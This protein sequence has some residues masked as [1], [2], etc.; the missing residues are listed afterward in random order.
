MY[1]LAEAISVKADWGHSSNIVGVDLCQMRRREDLCLFH[2]EP[3]CDDAAHRRAADGDAALRG[4]HAQR[5]AAAR[6]RRLRR[7]GNR[8]VR[9]A[10]AAPSGA[11]ASRRVRIAARRADRAVLLRA[12]PPWP[13]ACRRPGST[14]YQVLAPRPITSMPVTSSRSTRRASSRS[15]SGRGRAPAGPAGRRDRRA[16]PGGDR[17]RHPDARGRPLSPEHLLAQARA[18]TDALAPRC[19]CPRTTG[20]R[21]R[22]RR[23]PR[24]AGRGRHAGAAAGGRCAARR[25]SSRRA[26]PAATRARA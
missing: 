19:A 22:D 3:V 1:S 12:A 10:G 11:G 5:R 18:P 4:N 26:A 13:R 14:R 20:A 8:V 2:H 6:Q 21:R 15:A 23:G 17:P 25:S 16:R 24:R 7:D 9:P